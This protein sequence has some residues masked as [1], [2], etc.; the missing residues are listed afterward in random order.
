MFINNKKKISKIQDFLINSCGK[1]YWGT[2]N[3]IFSVL[4]YKIEPNKMKKHN[5]NIIGGKIYPWSSLNA[6][7]C[8]NMRPWMHGFKACSE[9]I[10]K[11]SSYRVFCYRC[12]R[13][14]HKGT[15]YD[16]VKEWNS[17]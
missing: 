13:H 5:L 9:V 10:E 11:G 14:T 8:G 12:L 4:K 6:C 2:N 3:D 1:S 16:V 17:Y 7:R 15:Y